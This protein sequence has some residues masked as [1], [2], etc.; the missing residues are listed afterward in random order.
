[1]G[2]QRLQDSGNTR[3]GIYPA[4][5]AG[6][7]LHLCDLWQPLYS[8]RAPGEVACLPLFGSYEGDRG[9]GP[10]LATTLGQ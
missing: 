7:T 9:H 10:P 6:Q 8:P 4:Q 1:M 2:S 5:Q 3:P